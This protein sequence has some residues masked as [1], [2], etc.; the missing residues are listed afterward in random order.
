V[1]QGGYDLALH[2][3]RVLADLSIR[4]L[5]EDYNIVEAFLQRWLELVV[6]IKPKLHLIN[7]VEAA[8]VDNGVFLEMIFGSEE[9]VGGKDSL[10]SLDHAAIVGA[11]LG[12]AKEFKDLGGRFEVDRTGVLFHREGSD[13]DGNQAVLAVR[14]GRFIM[15]LQQ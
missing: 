8:P 10:E 3:N 13:P 14:D 2:R 5:A 4:S 7:E 6:A 15:H 9:N 11:V 12:Q 1:R